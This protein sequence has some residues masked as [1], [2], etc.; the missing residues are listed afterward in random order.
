MAD[1]REPIPATREEI[2]QTPVGGTMEE[3]ENNR[4]RELRPRGELLK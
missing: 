4:K 2:A 1:P 3:R